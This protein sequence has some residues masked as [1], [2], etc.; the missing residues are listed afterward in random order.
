MPHPLSLRLSAAA[1]WPLAES[2]LRQLWAAET[3]VFKVLT[4]WTALTGK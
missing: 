4:C 3:T 2:S 1:A